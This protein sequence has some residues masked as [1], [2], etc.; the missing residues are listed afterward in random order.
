MFLFGVLNVNQ[1][2]IFL[3]SISGLKL[4][5][6]SSYRAM[7]TRVKPHLLYRK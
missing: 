4:L 5:L 6:N 1:E 3:L 7:K 2:I